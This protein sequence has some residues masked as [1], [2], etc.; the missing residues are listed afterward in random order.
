MADITARMRDDGYF[1]YYP[2]AE[3]FDDDVTPFSERKN[4]DRV[5]WTRA[6][7]GAHNAGN[8][9]GLRGVRKM[10]NWL[11]NQPQHLSHMVCG[12][13][14]TNAYPGL[15]LMANSEAGVDGDMLT[16]QKYF[17][18]DYLLKTPCRRKLPLRWFITLGISRIAMRCS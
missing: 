17:D 16:V 6:M 15:P 12:T 8:R 18:Q 3:S 11:E 10:Y 9:D 2:E 4:Y 7:S 1:N 5:F 13:N 14:S